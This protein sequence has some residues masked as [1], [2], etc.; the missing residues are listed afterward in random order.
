MSKN[1]KNTVEITP[2]TIEVN[3]LATIANNQ[4]SKANSIDKK[5]MNSFYK[6][7][8]KS[9]VKMVEMESL[10]ETTC[11]NK[12]NI[13]ISKGRLALEYKVT[14]FVATFAICQTL[15]NEGKQVNFGYKFFDFQ[16]KP[17]LAIEAV[18]DNKGQVIIEAIPLTKV[19][20]ALNA[21][22]EAY[23]AKLNYYLPLARES[24]A[25]VQTLAL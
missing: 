6:S 1:I 3:T 12:G 16:T 15:R 18:L 5:I 22:R 4:M 20:V 25:T 2:V 24:L 13:K 17:D 9:F 14:E 11:T 23:K 10:K 7:L 8:Q 21:N 19:Q